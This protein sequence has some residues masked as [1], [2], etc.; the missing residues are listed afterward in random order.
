[1]H[2]PCFLSSGSETADSDR[3]GTI[4]A[5]EEMFDKTLVQLW[6]EEIEQKVYTF[7]MYRIDGSS[8]YLLEVSL[9]EGDKLHPLLQHLL[10]AEKEYTFGTE[11]INSQ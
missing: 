5:P 11:P 4:V 9:I 1:M 3:Y 6:F 2:F 8:D 7:C 10:I